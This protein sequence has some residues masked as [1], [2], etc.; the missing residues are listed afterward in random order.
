INI[1]HLL[2]FHKSH[3]KIATLTGVK[4]LSRFGEFQVEGERVKKFTE[5]PQ[6]SEG[7]INGGFFVFR[8]EI[9]DYLEDKDDCDLEYGALEKLAKEG[10]LIVY[11]H[12]GFW[13][14]MDTYR[15]MKYLNR[16]WAEGKAEWK[17]WE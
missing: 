9:F 11:R 8:K 15:D 12:D 10:Q 17:I 6:A 1:D 2:E 7:L 16:L 5:K 4:P 13:A 3:G 14:C